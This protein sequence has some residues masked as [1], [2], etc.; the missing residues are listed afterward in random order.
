MDLRS[1][2]IQGI[3]PCFV[4][5]P[6]PSCT[7]WTACH[8][9]CGSYTKPPHIMSKHQGPEI[10]KN[11]YIDTHHC[12]VSHPSHPLLYCPKSSI[13]TGTRESI[14]ARKLLDCSVPTCMLQKWKNRKKQKE[15]H[16]L[17]PIVT[18]TI[19]TSPKCKKENVTDLHEM[20]E[21]EKILCNIKRKPPFPP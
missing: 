6:W 12:H 10:A 8:T 16:P 1:A 3:Q 4:T 18:V 7:S 15:K 17:P 9:G 5:W 14:I 19:Y 13:A 21:K 11:G 20:K 2:L